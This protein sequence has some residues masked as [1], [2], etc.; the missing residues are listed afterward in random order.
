MVSFPKG[1]GY[2]NKMSLGCPWLSFDTNYLQL[3]MFTNLLFGLCRLI[4]LSIYINT[5]INFNSKTWSKP[6]NRP[7]L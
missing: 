7:K 4:C 6:F 3:V 1:L 5:F 2:V